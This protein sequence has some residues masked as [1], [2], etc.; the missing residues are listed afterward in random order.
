MLPSYLQGQ[1]AYAVVTEIA[2]TPCY[3]PP[4]LSTYCAPS[5]TPEDDKAKGKWVIIEKDLNIKSG[6]W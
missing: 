2:I 1:I 5:S 6:L 4:W 3:L